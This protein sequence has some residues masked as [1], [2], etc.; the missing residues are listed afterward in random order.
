MQ[1]VNVK[2]YFIEKLT[3]E[4]REVLNEL[5]VEYYSGEDGWIL[6][7][8]TAEGLER[9]GLR[10]VI[11]PAG[12]YWPGGS[13]DPI[14]IDAHGRMVSNILDVA[15]SLG[16]EIEVPDPDELVCDKF[17]WARDELLQLMDNRGLVHY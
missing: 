2:E 4:Q 9:P 16:I 1:D 11:A 7:T 13:E 10:P 15:A 14:C 5:G 6:V 17:D 8:A 3:A 12:I